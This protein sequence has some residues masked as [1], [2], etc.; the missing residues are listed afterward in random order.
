[1]EYDKYVILTSNIII[2]S[3]KFT[4]DTYVNVIIFMEI[5]WQNVIYPRKLLPS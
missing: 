1:M 5:Y 2:K 3:T 4:Y